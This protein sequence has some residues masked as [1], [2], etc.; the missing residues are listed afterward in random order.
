[1]KHKNSAIAYVMAS[2]FVDNCAYIH[3]PILSNSRLPSNPATPILPAQPRFHSKPLASA[4][5][6]HMQ[7]HPFSPLHRSHRD[8][9]PPPP[10]SPA[11][12]LPTPVL[13]PKLG[14]LTSIL[15]TP[16]PPFPV[17]RG[18]HQCN[19][20]CSEPFPA[21][22]TRTIFQLDPGVMVTST[23]VSDS[24]FDAPVESV[25]ESVLRSSL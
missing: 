6:P 5:N 21:S 24:D 9:P 13:A 8:S 14:P 3:R 7:Q 11:P 25:F 16:S 12:S 4:R 1:M 10:D 15:S 18:Y 17:P 2:I 20:C 23:V 19:R 22:D